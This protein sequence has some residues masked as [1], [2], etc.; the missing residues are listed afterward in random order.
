MDELREMDTLNDGPEADLWR[1]MV[2]RL[3]S[4][5]ERIDTAVDIADLLLRVRM[6][7]L[8]VERRNAG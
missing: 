4:E 3:A 8:V 5:G 6:E 2:E 1:R 7:H